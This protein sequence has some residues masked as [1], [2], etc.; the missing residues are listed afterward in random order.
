MELLEDTMLPDDPAGDSSDSHLLISE[1]EVDIYNEF[2]EGT[3][4]VLTPRCLAA[5]RMASATR[6]GSMASNSVRWSGMNSPAAITLSHFNSKL[7]ALAARTSVRSTHRLFL[8]D[9][10]VETFGRNLG[11]EFLSVYPD[12]GYAYGRW[13]QQQIAGDIDG[14]EEEEDDGYAEPGSDPML[15]RYITWWLN[16]KLAAETLTVMVTRGQA[17]AG[18]EN[19]MVCSFIYIGALDIWTNPEERWPD[20]QSLRRAEAIC[21]EEL[22]KEE[23]A[24]LYYDRIG[25]SPALCKWGPLDA[26]RVVG[27]ELLSQIDPDWLSRIDASRAEKVAEEGKKAGMGDD[28]DYDEELF[29]KLMSYGLHE[30]YVSSRLDTCIGEDIV[31]SG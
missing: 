3:L 12:Q 8:S 29:L 9:G 31:S 16:R 19:S 17:L 25:F 22:Q 5:R 6:G 21:Q 10:Q 24:M 1:K 23:K 18:G 7:I 11:H 26:E 14:L 28:D 13:R 4:D 15:T 30:Y 2:I 27:R 20:E